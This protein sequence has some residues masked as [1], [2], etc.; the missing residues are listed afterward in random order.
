[1]D[2]TNT[3]PARKLAL[4]VYENERNPA[5]K[6][7]T[8]DWPAICNLLTNRT[9]RQ[10]REGGKGFS[11]NRLKPGTTRKNVNVDFMSM[12]IADIDNGTTLESLMPAIGEYEWFAYSSFKHTDAA[13]R[14]RIVFPLTKDV[15]AD[16]WG[17]VWDAFSTALIGGNNDPATKDPSRFFWLP[18]AHPDRIEMSFVQHNSGK[19]LDPDS[20]P[21]A[22]DSSFELPKTAKPVENVLGGPNGFPP[23]SLA[24]VA[25]RCAQIKLFKDTGGSKEPFWYA[26]LGVAKHAEDGPLLAHEW[27]KQ[28]AGYDPAETQSKMDQW[29]HGPT[30]CKRFTEVNESGCED[31]AFKGKVTS[32]IQLGKVLD[33]RPPELTETT[34]DGT[35]ATFTPPLWPQ[36]F[37]CRNNT[38]YMQIPDK[39]DIPQEVRVFSPMFYFT[40]RIELDDGTY[41][42]R[43]RMNVTGTRWREFDV[44]T[45][46][47]AEMRSLKATLASYEI[48]THND[49]LT[50]HYVKDYVTKLRENIEH[51]NTFR[52]F[53]WNEARTG[54]VIGDQMIHKDGRSKVRLSQ[55][56]LRNPMFTNCCAVSGTKEEWTAGVM[57]L[58]DRENGHPYQYT[59]CTQFGSPLTPL[60]GHS[61]WSGIPLALTSGDTGYGKTTCALI[62]MNA[63]YN[64]SQLMVSSVTPKAIV[65]RASVMNHVPVLYDELTQQLPDPEDLAD[66]VYTLTTGTPRAGMESGGR[67]RVPLPNF[68]GMHTFTANKNFMEKL[69]QAKVNPIATQMRIFEIPMESYDRM[70][71][72][73]NESTLHAKHHTLA[74]HLKDNVYG[75]W[76]DD[77]FRFITENRSLVEDKLRSTA[78]A[79]VAHLGGNAAKERFYAYH[80]ACTLVGGWIAKRIGAIAFDLNE[81]RDWAIRH[82]GRMRDTANQYGANT[83]DL[84]SKFL[85]DI[86]GQILV[87]KHYDLL[88]YRRN[89]IEVPMLPIRNAVN[90]RLVLGSDKERGKFYVSIKAI[91]EWCTKNNQTP[92]EFRR[93]LAGANLLR[94]ISDKGRGFDKEIY[95]AKGVPTVPLGKCRCYEVDFATVQGYIE[96]YVESNVKDFYSPSAVSVTKPEGAQAA[97]L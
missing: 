41:A 58:Y 9:I 53:G 68:K 10:Q 50:E 73:A 59:I 72:L 88:D 87:T 55:D 94:Q 67:E 96:E 82:I 42:L 81:L 89:Q 65:G 57:E 26:C 16:E 7:A 33:E 34:A 30:T 40:E 46:Q 2:S 4:T 56:T 97:A 31:C 15:P 6:S 86:H 76:T 77:Y 83:G 70:D 51:V 27:S 91:D 62:G 80:I 74:N 35:T 54:F 12:A 17:A 92:S 18:M 5:G 66:V 47:I 1:M 38:V 60:L 22:N 11:G 95:L 52:Q 61:E 71:S 14:Y 84:F 37:R 8:A 49:K 45:R 19:W 44:P 79:L 75:V 3:G 43:A 24:L 93:R 69:A 29:K 78:N 32:P 36:G 25:D 21:R 48:M 13:P 23:S 20:L 28:Y 64:G 85:S 90:A 39:D 63:L